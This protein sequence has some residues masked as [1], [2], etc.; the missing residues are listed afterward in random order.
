ME[1]P[2]A[3]MTRIAHAIGRLDLFATHDALEQEVRRREEAAAGGGAAALPS[4]ETAPVVTSLDAKLGR[5]RLKDEPGDGRRSPQLGAFRPLGLPHYAICRADLWGLTTIDYSLL[6]LF[7][8]FDTD[9]AHLNK[10]LAG[11]FPPTTCEGEGTRDEWAPGCVETAAPRVVPHEAGARDS[12]DGT[13]F[14]TEVEFSDRNLT[15]I[16]VRGTEFWRMSDWLED[17]R[18]WTE[19]V[20]FSLLSLVFPSIHVMQQPAICF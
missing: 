9:T 19:P 2:S 1:H 13:V 5:A 11:L 3:S 8:Y 15:V 6:S 10:A 17:V 14:W 12:A 4:A 20:V 16:A 7:A 18:M